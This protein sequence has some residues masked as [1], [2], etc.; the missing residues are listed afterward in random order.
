MRSHPD[1]P[2][3]MSDGSGSET[4]TWDV[5]CYGKPSK[6]GQISMRKWGGSWNPHLENS[7]HIVLK[8]PA[9]LSGFGSAAAPGD[10]PPSSHLG[11]WASPIA[12]RRLLVF[13]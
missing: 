7:T 13:S 8:P 9:V 11:R 3:E 12:N 10:R 2:L 4:R 6:P 5:W 1:Q